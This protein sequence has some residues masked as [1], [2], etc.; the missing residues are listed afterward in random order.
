MR[1]MTRPDQEQVRHWA[2]EVWYYGRITV[3]TIVA[4]VIVGW[5]LM[6]AAFA[7][8]PNLA[9]SISST[10]GE[11]VVRTQGDRTMHPLDTDKQRERWGTIGA[12]GDRR[13]LTPYEEWK[14]K[15]PLN[16][17]TEER[18]QARGERAWK[19]ERQTGTVPTPTNVP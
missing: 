14:G 11:W 6:T 8:W 1:T 15:R 10:Y 9:Y 16:P 19:S 12:D 2:T 5:M 18:H 4:V 3:L 13:G 17:P 7:T